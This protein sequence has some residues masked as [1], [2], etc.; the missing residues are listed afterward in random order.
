MNGN[1]F[2]FNELNWLA[3]SKLSCE[4]LTF[5]IKTFLEIGLTNVNQS[6][7]SGKWWV[8]SARSI[9]S[10]LSILFGENPTL[11]HCVHYILI[12]YINVD[13]LVIRWNFN[14]DCLEYVGITIMVKLLVVICSNN[15]EGQH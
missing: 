11:G 3:F 12:M 9:L 6:Q 1:K 7:T 13:T 2:K 4:Y 14:W 5:S 15:Y 8:V 10:L